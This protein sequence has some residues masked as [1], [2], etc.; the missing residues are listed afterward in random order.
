MLETCFCKVDI[1][2]LS[3]DCQNSSVLTTELTH[4]CTKPSIS[5]EIEIQP[6]SADKV[7]VYLSIFYDIYDHKQATK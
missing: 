3:Q 4:S 7:N 6:P 2:G 1:Y 5:N